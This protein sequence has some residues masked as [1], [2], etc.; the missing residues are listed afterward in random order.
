MPLPVG[1][2]L[3][4][5]GN[6]A[7]VAKHCV[8][9]VHSDRVSIT[10]RRIDGRKIKMSAFQGP[11]G[12][13][14]GGVAETSRR[15]VDG[16]VKGGK[17]KG[18][19]GSGGSG[20]DGG[21]GSGGGSARQTQ[22]QQV[23]K[24]EPVRKEPA[25]SKTH[26]G[27]GSSGSGNGFMDRV[28][29][30][31][32]RADKEAEEEEEEDYHKQDEEDEGEMDEDGEVEIVPMS[33]EEFMAARR[34]DLGTQGVADGRGS[35]RAGRAPSGGS[36]GKGGYGRAGGKGTESATAGGARQT[37]VGK[38]L[39]RGA[40]TLE[41]DAQFW[42]SRGSL[43]SK[44]TPRGKGGG[45]GGDNGKGKGNSNASDDHPGRFAQRGGAADEHRF[46]PD[47]LKA[48]EQRKQNSLRPPAMQAAVPATRGSRQAPGPRPGPAGFQRRASD[49]DDE[50]LPSL[51]ALRMN[52]GSAGVRW[53]E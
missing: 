38:A 43:V 47:K 24:K 40:N 3:V 17:G 51:D 26:G 20:G 13:G 41:A 44:G 2:V 12:Y 25:A 14:G 5:D 21:S 10:F 48:F 33:M 36:K 11:D 28:A 8:P 9:A 49:S 1:S 22:K 39:G 31:A 6:G 53:G 27:S 46:D 29:A 37:A 18:S 42:S 15:Q 35:G 45:K 4:L 16:V 34:K 32:A 19:G 50:E 7:N 30:A 23:Q 52:A